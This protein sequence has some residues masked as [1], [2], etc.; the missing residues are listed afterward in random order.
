V[1]RLY[2]DEEEAQV[3]KDLLRAFAEGKPQPEYY[4]KLDAQSRA[5]TVLNRIIREEK[6]Q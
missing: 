2:F 1:I 3:M 5:R 4:W 6:N